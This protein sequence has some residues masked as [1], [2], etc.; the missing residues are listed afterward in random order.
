[1]NKNNE[2]KVLAVYKKSQEENIP[3]II[4]CELTLVEYGDYFFSYLFKCQW[5]GKDVP[6]AKTSGAKI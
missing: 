1:M 2:I 4:I 6:L 3:H 5:R